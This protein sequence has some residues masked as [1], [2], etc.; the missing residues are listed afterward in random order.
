MSKV[1]PLKSLKARVLQK[2]VVKKREE[3]KIVIQIPELVV[4]PE[5]RPRGSS[6]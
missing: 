1:K 6:T 4:V 3:P 2:R 5:S